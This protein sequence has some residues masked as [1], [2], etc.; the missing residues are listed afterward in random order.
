MDKVIENLLNDG[1]KVFFTSDHG[2]VFAEGNGYN[3]N[4]Q[5][6]EDRAA[7]ALLILMKG[8]QEMKVLKPVNIELLINRRYILS[9]R[10]RKL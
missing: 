9:Y 4:R 1:F 5:L 6:I 8:L 3:P 10:Q 2:Y 7:R